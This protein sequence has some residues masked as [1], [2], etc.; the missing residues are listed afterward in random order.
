LLSFLILKNPVN[1]VHFP[2]RR[3]APERRGMG[4]RFPGNRLI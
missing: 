2:T 4:T 3:A 1:P